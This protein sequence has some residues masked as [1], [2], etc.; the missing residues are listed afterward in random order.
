MNNEYQKWL[1]GNDCCCG[2]FIHIEPCDKHKDVCDCDNILL[3]ISKLHTDD[4]VLQEQIDEL[5]GCCS[6]GSGGCECLYK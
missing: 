2:G 3:E 5:S 4:E 1:S 6:G